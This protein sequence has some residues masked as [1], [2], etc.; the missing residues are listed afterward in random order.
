[1]SYILD[2][3]RKSE[4]E[5]QLA[6]G[7]GAGLLFPASPEPRSGIGSKVILLGTAALLMTIGLAWWILSHPAAPMPAAPAIRLP[8]PTSQ[9]NKLTAPALQASIQPAPPPVAPP[10]PTPSVAPPSPANPPAAT[11]PGA[12]P[13]SR[14]ARLDAPVAMEK[15]A[16][17][18]SA[19]PAA[20]ALA[21]ARNDPPAEN[22]AALPPVTVSGYVRDDNGGNLAIINDR[23]V[24]EGEEVSP[25]LRL[26]KID[27]ETATFTY[28]GQRF[29]R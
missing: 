14:A 29:R 5:R 18:S 1:M 17:K 27:G 19:P 7:H 6:A 15:P 2:A 24:R 21:G 22:K 11:P 28:K 16:K 3:L 4:Q 20:P 23:L 10:A 25:G 8:T 12:S 9:P 26:E 13:E